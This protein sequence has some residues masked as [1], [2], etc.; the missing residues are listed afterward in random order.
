[1][2]VRA[3][4]LG[5]GSSGG[6]PRAKSGQLAIMAGGEAIEVGRLDLLFAEE[7]DPVAQVVDGDE[8]DVRFGGRLRT[9]RGMQA[10]ERHQQG[11]GEYQAV[12]KIFI[13]FQIPGQMLLL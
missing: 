12:Q 13:M 7:A 10:G 6:V 2:S 3:T 4:I 11:D 9:L 5:C 8:Q 1:M